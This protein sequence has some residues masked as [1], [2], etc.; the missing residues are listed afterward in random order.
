MTIK[1]GNLK[2]DVYKNDRAITQYLVVIDK[3]AGGDHV[4]AA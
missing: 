3:H 2:A 1:S 4:D